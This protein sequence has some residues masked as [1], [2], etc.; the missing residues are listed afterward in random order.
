M[1]GARH[2]AWADGTWREASRFAGMSFRPLTGIR[3]VDL[4]SS[5][6]GPTCT[7]ILGA[8]GADV[9]KVE[10]PQR[11]DEA[12]AWGPEFFE[13]GSVMFFA[14]NASKR[15]LA[16][17]VKAPAGRDVLLRLVDG[18]DVF[19]QSLRPG[20]AAR[21]GYGWDDL[22]ARNRRLVYCSI[23]A[24]GKRGPLAGKPG[25]DPLLQAFTGI[26]SVTGEPER[27]GVRVGTSLIDIGTGVWAAL[28]IVSA[29][30]ER[31]TTG[32]GRD[33]DVSLL[34]TGLSLVGYQLTEALR[35]GRSPG[36]F[37]TAFPL[38]APYE[39][40]ATADGELMI[41]A[42]NDRL[43][44]QLCDR[45]GLPEL[46]AD[47]RFRTNPDRLAN[48]EALLPP[49]RE[50]L[51]LH[52]T[53]HWLERLDGIPVAPVQEVAEAARH[54]QTRATEIVQSLAGIETLALPLEIDGER[55][56]HRSQPPT[57]GLHSREILAELGYA[58]A[59]IDT[60][61]ADGITRLT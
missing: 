10:H 45:V 37:G 38:I 8:L 27:P 60:L 32:V 47:P 25:Y 1:P 18:A 55:V 56:S 58:P 30:L 16:L 31:A 6:A 20:T 15:S 22:H 53:D 50:R 54:E 61:A 43:F 34:D 13:G 51:A 46:V 23:G 12:R 7:E 4:T 19:V 40:F 49:L 24:F 59:A 17:D 52:T 42:A 48:R 11:G 21:L 41:A 26:V 39:V 35:T 36:R 14:A 28:G 3:V 9:V 5:L 29:L 57:L 33:V 44:A 2:R